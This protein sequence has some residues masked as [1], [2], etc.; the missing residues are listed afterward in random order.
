MEITNSKIKVGNKVLK[1]HG[2]LQLQQLVG[3]SFSYNLP[4][5]S[6]DPFLSD[7]KHLAGK[8]I[9][10]WV[11]ADDGQKSFLIGTVRQITYVQHSYDSGEAILNGEVKK[12]IYVL[13]LLTNYRLTLTLAIL[14]PFVFLSVLTYLF[15]DQKKNLVEQTG[16][17]TAF[18]KRSRGARSPAIYK[19]QL[20][21]FKVSFEREYQG[22]SRFVALNIGDEIYR[23]PSQGYPYNLKQD[24]K[25]A[26]QRKFSWYMEDVDLHKLK[27]SDVTLPYVYLHAVNENSNWLFLYDLYNYVFDKYNIMDYLFPSFISSTVFLM[28]GVGIKRGNNLFWKIY[29][30]VIMVTFFILFII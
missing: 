17:V 5:K 25:P 30:G 29:C 3:N 12:L 2:P 4:L 19:F 14:I 27:T 6:N 28:M 20:Q 18:S 13:S 22:V 9:Y 16:T 10:I 15:I 21:E 23:K 1:D 7:Q 26:D 24:L 11:T 8:N